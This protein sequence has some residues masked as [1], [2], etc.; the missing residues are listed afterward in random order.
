MGRLRRMLR[1][2]AR[3]NELERALVINEF[4]SLFL[5]DF[6]EAIAQADM[7]TSL[8]EVGDEISALERRFR[9]R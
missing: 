8:R 5:D 4:R 6:D 1:L 3:H 2:S 7:R 9:W